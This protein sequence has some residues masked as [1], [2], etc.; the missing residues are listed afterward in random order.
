MKKIAIII[1]TFNRCKLLE[2][3][4]SQ[5]LHQASE[6]LTFKTTVIVVNDGS[7]D[8]TE[9]MLNNKFPEVIQKKTLGNYWYTKSMNV[10]FQEALT[11]NVDYV[12]TLNDDIEIK[13]DYLKQIVNS[14]L[15]YSNPIIMGSTSITYE[16]PPRVTFS[17]VKNIKWWRVKQYF[18]HNYLEEIDDNKL[19]G[20]KNSEILPGRGMLIDINILKKIGFFDSKLPQYGSDDEFCLRAK[21]NGFKVYVSWDSIIYS[22]HELTGDGSPILKQSFLNYTKSFFNKY[23]RNYWKKFFYINIKYGDVLTLPISTIIF[24]LGEFYSYFKNKLK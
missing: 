17:G 6:N 22:H 10:G 5:L 19:N 23:S 21:K 4:L 9:K 3:S 1:P 12:L 8:G 14:I 13:H 24:F 11:L 18:Y 2:I 15:K 20:I 16:K 7:T